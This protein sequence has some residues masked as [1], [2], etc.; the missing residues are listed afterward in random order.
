MKSLAGSSYV[1]LDTAGGD[2]GEIENMNWNCM[3]TERE[4]SL[5]YLRKYG[6]VFSLYVVRRFSM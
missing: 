5:L 3:K 2:C 4:I 6:L 1:W